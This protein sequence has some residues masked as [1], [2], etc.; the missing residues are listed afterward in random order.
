VITVHVVSRPL[1]ELQP[2]GVGRTRI[3]NGP[4]ND[5]GEPREVQDGPPEGGE[6]PDLTPLPSLSR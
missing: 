3:W 5:T 1:E 2:P 4:Q 6:V